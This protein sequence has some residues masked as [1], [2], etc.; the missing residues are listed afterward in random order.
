MEKQPLTTGQI[1]Q[2]CHVTLRAVLKWITSGKLKAYRTPGNHSR[3][4]VDDFLAFLKRYHM[5][6]PPEM[7]ASELKKIL[8]VDDDHGVVQAI[9]RVLFNE[10]KYRVETALDGFS[11]G[12]KLAEFHPDLMILDIRMPGMDG[13]EVCRHVRQT[14]SDEQVKIL[15]VSGLVEDAEL[16]KILQLGANDYLTKPFGNEA[17]LSKITALLDEREGRND[18]P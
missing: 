1:A 17:L 11:A 12:K 9:Q 2:H 13:Y 18:R 5:P 16:K 3:V 14:Y 7:E 8:V 15:A 4:S 6:I 10:G